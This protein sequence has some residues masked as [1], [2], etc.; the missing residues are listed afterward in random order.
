MRGGQSV[1]GKEQGAMDRGY[2]AGWQR[3]K[4]EWVRGNVPGAWSRVVE[5]EGQ[6]KR[7]KGGGRERRGRGR[8]QKADNLDIMV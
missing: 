5:G 7:V 1:K 2:G 4:P 8:E 3:V 6:G